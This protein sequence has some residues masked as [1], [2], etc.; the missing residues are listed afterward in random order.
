MNLFIG[1]STLTCILIGGYFVM[2]GEMTAGNIAEFVIYINK[3]A[4]PI[5]AIGWTAN[6]ITRAAVSQKRINEFLNE[7]PEV[8]SKSS[9]RTDI[10]SSNIQF[11]NVN[12]YYPNTGTHA[13]KDFNLNIKE[14]EKIC[15]LGKTGS[16]KSTLSHLLLRMYDVN[17]GE[18]QLGDVPIRDYDIN[19]LRQQFAYVPQEV[20]L[21]SDTI[22]NN[23]AFGLKDVTEDQ[24][25]AAAKKASIYNEIMSLPEGMNTVVGERGVTLS[26][27]QKQ[28]ISLARAL[29]RPSRILLLDES[30]S[31]VDTQTEQTIQKNLSKE[32]AEK[33]V[34]II[35]HRIFKNWD[36][37][38]IIFMIDGQIVE[39]GTHDELIA[40]KGH[41]YELY[42]YQIQE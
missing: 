33:T 17:S 22:Y 37:D 9:A 8:F 2:N 42:Q 12:F 18:I 35:T 3:L 10:K 34:I 29:L 1:L 21:F 13:L 6:M 23:I 11:N 24:V 36:F 15:I 28:R 40:L 27:G 32:I 5:S 25:I 38:K 7:E 26:G 16:G 20:F 19:I 39:Q 31:A 14:H 4:F 41:Y 30:L